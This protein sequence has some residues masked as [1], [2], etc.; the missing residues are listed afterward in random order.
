MA[1]PVSKTV[2]ITGASSGIGRVCAALLARRGFRVFAGVRRL[3]DGDA[4]R[5]ESTD[6]GHAVT[7]LQIDVTDDTTVTSA[8]DALGVLLEERGLDGLVNNAGIG[9]TAP[10]EYISA[11]ALRRQFDVN[12]FGQIA[13]TQAFLPLVRRARGRIVNM[14]SVGSEL[15]IPF[16]GALCASKSALKSLNDALRL[17]LRSFG[18]Q[19]V[20]VEPGAIHTPAVDKTLGDIEE[21]IRALPPEGVARYGDMLRTF[22][23][24]AYA[25]EISGSPPEVVA[26]AVHDALTARRPRTRY[27]V[28][29]DAKTMVTLPR[30]VPERLLDLLR[31]RHLGL[32]TRFGPQPAAK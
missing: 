12:V 3:G 11:D 9:I 27:V 21:V 13:V 15:A 7:P 32:P 30:I 22:G 1:E 6:G 17:E 25:R 8:A 23:E 31:L 20:L 4:L 5:A 10:V 24:R 28:G 2:L 26:R 19:V 14:G 16:G 18:I 29:A